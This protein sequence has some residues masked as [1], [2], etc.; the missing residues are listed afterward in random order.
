MAH[1][2]IGGATYT[3]AKLT[4]LLRIV[5]ILAPAL[6]AAPAGA[7]IVL[8]KRPFWY[9]P[10]IHLAATFGAGLLVALAACALFGWLLRFVPA[11]RLKSVGRL[12]KRCRFSP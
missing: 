3:A 4:H 9:Y 11:P 8:L 1:Q 5:A 12:R 7:S 6:N 2:P 10:L